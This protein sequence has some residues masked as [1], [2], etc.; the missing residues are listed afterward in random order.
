[1]TVTRQFP[2]PHVLRFA[3]LDSL[4]ATVRDYAPRYVPLPHPSPRNRPWLARHPWF[5]RQV[6]PMLRTR[7]GSLVVR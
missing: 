5:E 6:L 7:V 1:M 2:A 4:L 3:T